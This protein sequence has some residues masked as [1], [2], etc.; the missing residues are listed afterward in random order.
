ML[1]VTAGS[2]AMARAVWKQFGVCS[3]ATP[4]VH[5]C[6][7]RGREHPRRQPYLL[8]R[9]PGYLLCPFG[10]G[11]LDTLGE[12]VEPAGPLTHELVVVEPFG[13]YAVQHAQRECVVGAR[14]EL[15]PELRPLGSLGE[16][17]VHHDEARALLE[18]VPQ[19]ELD[20]PIGAAAER[21]LP[22]DQ[23][24]IG[25]DIAL[26]VRHVVLPEGE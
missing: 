1:P 22:P 4:P 3:N 2:R 21:V 11:P 5:R 10:G 19:R 26:V 6:G 24:A 18:A 25:M 14:P 20:L 8:G 9:D 16:A 15:Q 7:A 12:P 23:D 17:R 13:D